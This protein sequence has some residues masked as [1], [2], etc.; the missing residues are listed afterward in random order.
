MP[1]LGPL[2]RDVPI[3]VQQPTVDLRFAPARTA[4]QPEGLSQAEAGEIIYFDV[5]ATNRGS[6]T[7]VNLELEIEASAGLEIVGQ[8]TKKA[9]NTFSLIAPQQ[10]INSPLAFRV[11]SEGDH[12]VRLTARSGP[13]GNAIGQRDA[14]VRG[15]PRRP[16][17]PI[18][19]TAIQLPAQSYAGESTPVVAL[20]QVKN[21]GTAPLSNIGVEITFDSVLKPR[22]IDNRNLGRVQLE[23]D[24]LRW[25]P[26]D[27]QPDQVES[28]QIEFVAMAP[29]DQAMIQ[30]MASNGQTSDGKRAQTQILSRSVPPT[31]VTPP[32]QVAPPTQVAPPGQI[33]PPGAILP[34]GAAGAPGAVLPPAAAARSGQWKIR[35]VDLGDPIEVNKEARYYLE[36][37]NEQ[38]LADRNVRIQ[39]GI[40]QGVD[41]RSVTDMSGRAVLTGPAVD[42]V[43]ELERI[44]Y[45]QPGERQFL[46]VIYPRVPQQMRLLASVASDA[47][48]TPTRTD[49]P[50]TVIA[51]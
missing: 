12:Q 49:E 14:T 38:N 31:Q 40:P 32:P 19:E 34:P 16:R 33:A 30:V 36:V 51:R 1:N 13:G 3:R 29:K 35:I 37:V 11:L 15:L 10:S 28:L 47:L 18:V 7:L 22:F 45:F 6:Q 26:P 9:V 20:V 2:S 24:R 48:P 8:P 17:A 44:E 23:N 25:Q 4:S 21:R 27:L 50:V 39:L 43:A 42:G 5:E 46:F 41:L